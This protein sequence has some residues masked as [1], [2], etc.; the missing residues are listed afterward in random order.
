MS[1]E[2]FHLD[3]RRLMRFAGEAGHCPDC[4]PGSFDEGGS[5]CPRHA[6]VRA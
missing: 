2:R 4:D 5:A 6:W 1:V 3:E